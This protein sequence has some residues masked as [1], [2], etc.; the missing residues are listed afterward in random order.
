MDRY[1]ALQSGRQLL[2]QVAYLFYLSDP[3]DAVAGEAVQHWMTELLARRDADASLTAMRFCSAQTD[4]LGV[5]CVQEIE[6]LDAQRVD[7]D[8]DDDNCTRC[9]DSDS[10]ESE[11]Q[12]TLTR[13][14][15]DSTRCFLWFVFESDSLSYKVGLLFCGDSG[16]WVQFSIEKANDRLLDTRSGTLVGA[17]S[18]Q[19]QAVRLHC[20]L[21]ELRQSMWLAARI[22]KPK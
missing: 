2:C 5:R 1:S 10:D 21:S 17:R 13:V 22:L 3:S 7:L 11:E 18:L 14:T 8:N 9:L 6:L 4:A 12:S 19:Q 15:A 16:R 20:L